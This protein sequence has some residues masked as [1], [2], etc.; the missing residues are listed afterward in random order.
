[1][2][3]YNILILINLFITI[4][5]FNNVFLKMNTP[6][7]FDH[8]KIPNFNSNCYNIHSFAIDKFI[9]NLNLYEDKL[10]YFDNNNGWGS[11]YK[12]DKIKILKKIANVELDKYNVYNINIVTNIYTKLPHFQMSLHSFGKKIIA[13]CDLIP[14]IDYFIEPQYLT[15]YYRDFVD[16]KKNM[17]YNLIPTN[18][19]NLYTEATFTPAALSFTLETTTD[20]V[21]YYNTI[22]KYVDLY[23][24]FINYE[25]N[26]HI[27]YLN[28]NDR[29]YKLKE[30]LFENA[31]GANVIKKIFKDDLD[32][33]KKFSLF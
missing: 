16:I 28:I 24:S 3:I 23:C 4:N 25:N 14:K 30:V 5:S 31:P 1:M 8:S 7:S 15:T 12:N 26:S 2:K 32:I 6:R 21:E 18:I 27:G 22:I 9:N 17:T 11:L 13:T 33:F 20:C 19:K 29:D 10:E